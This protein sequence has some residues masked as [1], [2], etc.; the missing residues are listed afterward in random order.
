MGNFLAVSAFRFQPVDLVS[1]AIVEYAMRYSVSVEV[2][3]SIDFV[4]G[5]TD[6][7]VYEP[8]NDWTVVLWP[9][10]FNIHDF[11]FVRAIAATKGW[12]VSTVHVYDGDYWEH[13]CCSGQS[14]LHLFNSRPAYWKDDADEDYSR[15]QKYDSSP[16]R[17]A[18]ALGIAPSSIQPYLVDVEPLADLQAKAFPDDEYSLANFWVFIDF[19][20]RLGIK[21]PDPPHRLGAIL[22][23]GE[24]FMDKLP[25]A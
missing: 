22:R 21:Y 4:G 7:Q 12:M 20:K 23:I 17:L 19:W 14:E 9:D 11:P 16:S 15:I 5:R 24:D 13:L 8:A 18:E 3:P 10:Y 25:A 2:Q 1:Q 6:A